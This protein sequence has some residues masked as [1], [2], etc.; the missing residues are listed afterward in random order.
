MSPNDS[1]SWKVSNIQFDPDGDVILVIP[2]EAQKRFQVNSHSLCL[3]SSV[4]RVMLGANAR[5]S[6]GNAL[7]NRDASSP[8]IEITLGD[9][10]PNALALLLRIVHHQY[11]WVPRTLDD[12]QLYQVAIVCDKYD[13]RGVLGLWLDQWIPEDTKSGGKI[14]GDQWLFIAYAFGKQALF[15]ELSK[16]LILTST[17]DA[18]GSLL[19]PLPTSNSVQAQSSFNHY[20]PSSIVAEISNRHKRTI[21]G[22]LDYIHQLIEAYRAPEVPRCAHQTKTDSCDAFFL[23]FLL[24]TFAKHKVYPKPYSQQS[25]ISIQELKSQVLDGLISPKALVFQKNYICNCDTVY[26]GSYNCGRCRYQKADH[27]TTCSPIPKLKSQIEEMT[28]FQGLELSQF[29]RT[30]KNDRATT[31]NTVPKGKDLWDYL[32]YY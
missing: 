16:D 9:D 27:I 26:Y 5:F 1:A 22:M 15:T 7:R 3:A 14:T 12:N 6:E 2:S 21:Q 30:T 17:V 28:N 32:D 29:V 18:G 11:D 20:I 25:S 10:N 8:P 4:F 31:S 19:A 24:N 23:G 13:M